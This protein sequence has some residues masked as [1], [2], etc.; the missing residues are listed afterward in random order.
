MHCGVATDELLLATAAANGEVW[1]ARGNC[2][3]IRAET[4][5]Q[6]AIGLQSK[7]KLIIN[8][9]FD[10]VYYLKFHYPKQSKK[11]K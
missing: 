9:C 5:C 4:C 3:S 10:N 8:I 11:A 7:P 2:V 1:P 6:W